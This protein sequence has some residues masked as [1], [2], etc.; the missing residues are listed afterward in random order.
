MVACTEKW[1]VNSPAFII[2]DEY[3]II[4]NENKINQADSV[5]LFTQITLKAETDLLF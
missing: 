5:V 3:D 4:C 1:C 2:L